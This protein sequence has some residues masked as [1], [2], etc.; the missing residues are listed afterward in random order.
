MAAIGFYSFSIAAPLSPP[1][2][3]MRAIDS[4]LPLTGRGLAAPLSAPDVKKRQTTDVGKA[5]LSALGDLV[6]KVEQQLED[7]V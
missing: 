6:D 5:L 1:K 4:A 7:E 3:E 2:A